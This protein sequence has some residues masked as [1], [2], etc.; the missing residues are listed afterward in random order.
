MSDHNK[1]WNEQL[2][3]N[4]HLV[5]DKRSRVQRM[6][7][8]IAPSYDLNNRLH[9][10]GRDQY[11]RKQTVRIAAP[12]PSDTVVDVACGT[13]DLT[14]AFSRITSGPV[15]G[16]DFTYAMLPLASKKSAR[17]GSSVIWINAD[18]QCLPLSDACCDIV[19]I[20][21]GI[22]NVQDIHAA[23]KEFYRVLRPNGR[24]VI[25]EFSEPQ[26]PL[27]RFLNRV[28]SYHLMPITAS[29]IARDR[30]GAYQYLPRSIETFISRQQMKQLL[31]ETGFVSVEQHPMTFGVC[32]CYRGVKPMDS[33][34]QDIV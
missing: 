21:F 10:F 11:W 34:Q 24:L 9:S 3:H 25:L 27:V 4:P 29:L 22:R 12:G 23:L 26:Q 8:A 5:A 31:E 17:A 28:Y 13:G 19:S 30:S 33:L 16:I 1:A 18:A 32:V 2:L 20:A 6:F 14:L 15:I 7:S